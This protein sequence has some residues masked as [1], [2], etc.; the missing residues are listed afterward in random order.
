MNPL[1][2][3]MKD[4]KKNLKKYDIS[5][6]DKHRKICHI[7]INKKKQQRYQYLLE[8]SNTT[9]DSNDGIT[10]NINIIGPNVNN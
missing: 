10:M 4:E 1:M 9:C 3:M 5:Y 7:L 8:T 2:M 6:N